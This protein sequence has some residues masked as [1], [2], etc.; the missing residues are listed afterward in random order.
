MC[1]CACACLCE[2]AHMP[3]CICVHVRPR[4]HMRVRVCVSCV[5]APVFELELCE[6]GW[7]S[8]KPP[9]M[10]LCSHVCT[11]CS[12]QPKALHAGACSLGTLW[13]HLSRLWST[14]QRT[15]WERL[16]GRPSELPVAPGRSSAGSD[17]PED[18]ACFLKSVSVALKGQP[19]T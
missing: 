16:G 1:V 12:H 4:A 6:G 11:A 15:H 10:R 3:L 14:L 2:C 18:R 13:G 19:E 7:P 17:A 5:L 8:M 9:P